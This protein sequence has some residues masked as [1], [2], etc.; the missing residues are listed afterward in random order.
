MENRRIHEMGERKGELSLGKCDNNGR[1]W[2]GRSGTER[3][4]AFE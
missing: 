2:A 4:V 1:G 3:E